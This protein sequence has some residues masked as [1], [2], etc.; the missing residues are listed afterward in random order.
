[1]NNVDDID[2][3][4]NF[5]DDDLFTLLDNIVYDEEHKMDTEEDSLNLCKQCGIDSDIVEDSTLGVIVCR[6]CGGVITTTM[7]KTPEWR[8]FNEDG[9]TGGGRCSSISNPFLP[10]S[11]LGTSISGSGRSKIQILHSWSKMP[12][13]ERSLYIVLKEI[14]S[15]CESANI[16]KCIEHDAK[17]LYKN[18]S[19]CRHVGGK[20]KGKYIIIRGNNRKSLIAA[21]VFFACKRKKHTRSPKEIALIFNLK[22]TEITKGCKTFLKL[23][24]IK[25]MAYEYNISSAEHFIPR[26][27]KK[28]K[29]RD[30]VC[31]DQAT[32]IVVNI[33]KLNVA[34]Q[35]TPTSIAT[36]AILLMSELNG[37]PVTRKIIASQFEISE[38]T[39]TKAYR[40]L[41]E[42]KKYILNT[43]LTNLFV[44]K[45]DEKKRS[46]IMPQLLIDKFNKMGFDTNK[47]IV[48]FDDDE[49]E[50]EELNL[51]NQ[52]T[53]DDLDNYIDSINLEVY[54]SIETTEIDF[55]DII[56]NMAMT[57]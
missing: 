46:L 45:L 54:E 3:I 17:I 51:E 27:C 11:S 48:E 50:Y 53:E 13:K 18:I 44:V 49:F 4:E 33:Q 43:E 38:V 7:D 35:H 24:N 2:D 31:I 36:G 52:I 21:C 29:I 14:Q 20:S 34:S 23:M 16:L 40:K 6:N 15:K 42:Y 10:Q 5:D 12:Y 30:T 19:E 37:L 32:Q 1:M 25:K 41:C 57:I 26:F 9:K 47:Y 55:N 39:I 56:G 28:L 8:Q 22:Y